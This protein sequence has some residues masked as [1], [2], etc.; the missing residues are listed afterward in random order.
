MSQD[1]DTLDA[2]ST[3]S[4]QQSRYQ[5]IVSLSQNFL[6]AEITIVALLLTAYGIFGIQSPDFAMY[7]ESPKPPVYSDLTISFVTVNLLMVLSLLFLCLS[8]FFTSL[9]RFFTVVTSP[10]VRTSASTAD[11]SI[12][13]NRRVL[14]EIRL[15]YIQGSYRLLI[16]AGL[17]S[18]CGILYYWLLTG[19]LQSA[20]AIDLGVVVPA[21]VLIQ[22]LRGIT[23]EEADSEANA[24]PTAVEELFNDDSQLNRWDKLTVYRHEG[25]LMS[26]YAV[27]C[28]LAILLFAVRYALSIFVI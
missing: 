22:K 28:I 3:I 17:G 13:Y 2:E 19:E 5:H 27:L 12:E 21:P 18:L 20:L 9:Y 6:G 7:V 23:K 24:V 8:V 14:E 26:T 16:F 10:L 15:K 1:R 4:Y 11:W 25:L